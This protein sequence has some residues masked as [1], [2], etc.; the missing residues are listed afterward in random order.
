MGSSTSSEARWDEMLDTKQQNE[1][2][3]NGEDDSP[4]P[5]PPPVET[6]EMKVV[7]K[8]LLSMLQASQKGLNNQSKHDLEE[9]LPTVVKILAS[10]D[11]LGEKYT[12]SFDSAS[13]YSKQILAQFHLDESYV[14]SEQT[15]E[16]FIESSEQS[17]TKAVYFTVVERFD[18]AAVESVVDHFL[19]FRTTLLKSINPKAKFNIIPCLLIGPWMLYLNEHGLCIP[20]IHLS[21]I[22]QCVVLAKYA[23]YLG[24]MDNSS[25]KQI[26]EK[27]VSF[28]AKPL[29]QFGSDNSSNIR[30]ANAEFIQ[31]LLRTALPDPLEQNTTVSHAIKKLSAR[32]DEA[33]LELYLDDQKLMT[34]F[35]MREPIVSFKDHK[36]LDNFT[37]GIAVIDHNIPR[38]LPIVWKLLQSFDALYAV[39]IA[40]SDSN[41][42]AYITQDCPFENLHENC[43][44]RFVEIGF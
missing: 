44:Y 16:E 8:K 42:K 14:A 33:G 13:R 2:E 37:Q 25:M 11:E 18:N 30:I 41:D 28:N 20:Q 23:V 36:G 27:V 15:S 1:G 34:K 22:Y 29:E 9:L 12:R 21:G 39:R 10:P 38:T 31:S 43:S 4:P 7:R 17:D 3:E 32:S 6:P 40:A 35:G 24:E 5:P 19:P 26:A